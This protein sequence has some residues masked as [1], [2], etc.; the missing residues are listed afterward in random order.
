ML[1]VSLPTRDRRALGLPGSCAPSLHR[2]PTARG[3]RPLRCHYHDASKC[4]GILAPRPPSSRYLRGDHSSDGAAVRVPGVVGPPV[5]RGAR[6][7]AGRRAFSPGYS[8]LRAQGISPVH[9]VLARHRDERRAPRASSGPAAGAGGGAFG[10]LR[11]GELY[12]AGAGSAR[13]QQPGPV[14]INAAYDDSRGFS[15]SGQREAR[16]LLAGERCEQAGQSR[17]LALAS[18][19]GLDVLTTVRS[20]DVGGGLGVAEALLVNAIHLA[21][22]AVGAPSVRR[23]DRGSLPA[24]MFVVAVP[25]G[26]QSQVTHYYSLDLARGFEEYP[27]YWA[28]PAV[29]EYRLREILVGESD[30]GGPF[31]G[32]LP[33]PPGKNRLAT[34]MYALSEDWRSPTLQIQTQ[35]AH[36]RGH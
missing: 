31:V 27:I 26:W 14:I 35:P 11:P 10:R 29:G 22:H 33:F 5:R 34:A 2:A 13:I 32:E 21:S 6:R 8:F 12:A 16:R 36:T 23:I 18:N 30:R 25:D 3:T 19:L 17:L 4:S 9:R 20:P 24:E 15:T 28:G 1:G 7:A